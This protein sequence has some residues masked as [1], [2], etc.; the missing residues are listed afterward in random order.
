MK[1][2]DKGETYRI[3]SSI[4][5]PVPKTFYPENAN[6]V[7]HLAPEIK[8]PC[9]LKPISSHQFGPKFNKK[10]VTAKNAGE[11]VRSYGYFKSN[12][13]DMVIQEEIPGDDRNLIT[14]NAVLNNQSEPL[15]FF[16]HR[17][18]IQNPPKYGV[19]A[20]GESVWEPRIIEPAMKFLESH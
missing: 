9:I 16:M 5:V 7:A 18:V 13:F 1:F 12:G 14:L 2:I 19:V 20:L 6:E 15:A 3:A 17:R 4:S 10:L 11:L 8:Y